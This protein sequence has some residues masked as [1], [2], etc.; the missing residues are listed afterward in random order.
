MAELCSLQGLTAEAANV[1][2]WQEEWL[3][4]GSFAC[5]QTVRQEDKK[6]VDALAASCT[7]CLK[8]SVML[9]SPRWG[10]QHLQRRP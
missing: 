10:R 1:E 4:G 5:P 7:A 6:P 8:A 2:G 9:C 3:M